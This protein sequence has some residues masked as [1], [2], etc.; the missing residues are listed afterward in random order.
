MGYPQT[1]RSQNGEMSEGSSDGKYKK[2]VRDRG[3]IVEPATYESRTDL[4][5]Y[6]FGIH[7]KK[8]KVA[9]DGLLHSTPDFVANPTAHLD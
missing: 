8:I 5:D 9:P 4:H 6:Y 2:V 1:L 3:G 7:E